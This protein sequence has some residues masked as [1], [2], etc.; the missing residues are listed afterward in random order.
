MVQPPWVDD[1][2]IQ[3]LKARQ[4]SL[5]SKLERVDKNVEPLNVGPRKTKAFLKLLE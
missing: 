2:L 1:E 5:S 4:S 3:A